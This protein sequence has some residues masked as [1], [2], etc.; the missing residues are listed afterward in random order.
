MSSPENN[1]KI[2]ED[3]LQCKKDILRAKDIIPG[4][5]KK[6]ADSKDSVK[7]PE[8]STKRPLFQRKK[9]KLTANR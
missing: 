5:A 9:A 2:D 4:A 7:K 8:S 1:E 6:A 3:I